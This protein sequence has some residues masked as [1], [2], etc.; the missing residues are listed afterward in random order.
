MRLDRAQP[1]PAAEVIALEWHVDYWNYIGWRDPFSSADYSARQSAYASS[2]GLNGV[3]TPQMV[4]DGRTKFVGSSEARARSAIS[5]SVAS[6][7]P[8]IELG[9]AQASSADKLSVHIPAL[10]NATSGDTPELFL[11]LTESGLRSSVTRGENRGR[12]LEHTGVVRE[13]HLLGSVNPSASP[14]F[15]TETVL[16]LN[17][18]WQRTNLRAVVFV[19][20]RNSR[21][22][23]AAAQILFASH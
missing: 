2:F 20:E 21:R 5:R 15:A 19:Q 6:A 8:V 23:L 22:V 11:A 9:L 16:K 18:A 10:P 3:Y 13:F 7:K 4:V 12:Q 14:A 17:P 1:V